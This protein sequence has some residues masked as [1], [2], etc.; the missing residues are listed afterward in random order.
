MCTADPHY[1]NQ[2]TFDQNDH[3]YDTNYENDGKICIVCVCN[4]ICNV[5]FF[6][7][8]SQLPLSAVTIFFKW[9]SFVLNRREKPIKVWS[10]MRV[11]KWWRNFWVMVLLYCT[12]WG[13]REWICCPLLVM[14]VK[15]PERPSKQ[16][17][18]SRH[19]NS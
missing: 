12:N 9:S 19:K 15:N 17:K 3:E 5:M 10:S 2:C 13:N 6:Y 16:I 14:T 18:K 7:Y 4:S 8:A 1:N 11:S